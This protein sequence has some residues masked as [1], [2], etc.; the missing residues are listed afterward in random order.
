MIQIIKR[1]ARKTCTC[2]QCGCLFSYEPEDIKIGGT[3]YHGGDYSYI[4]CPQCNVEIYLSVE[5]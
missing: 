3:G 4:K 1:G 5:K 2:N